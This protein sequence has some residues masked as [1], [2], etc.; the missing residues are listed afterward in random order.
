MVYSNVVYYSNVVVGWRS[1]VRWRRLCVRCE[2]C[3]S[4]RATSLTQWQLSFYSQ[5]NFTDTFSIFL[6]YVSPFVGG[7]EEECS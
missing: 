2:G 1:D 4:T 6:G 5:W 7:C 3:C